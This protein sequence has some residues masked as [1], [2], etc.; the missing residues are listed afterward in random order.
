ME[1]EKLFFILRFMELFQ[2]LVCTCKAPRIY[3]GKRSAVAVVNDSPVDCQSR[4]R[5]SPQRGG[6]RPG[7]V[8]LPL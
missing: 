1:R 6:R 5:A 2:V 7:G 8:N 3:E 4:D